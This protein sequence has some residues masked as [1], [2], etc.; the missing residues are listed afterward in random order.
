MNT[1]IDISSVT[2]KTQ[3]LL[4]RPWLETDAEDLYE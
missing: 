1:P 3:R 4:L 2:I